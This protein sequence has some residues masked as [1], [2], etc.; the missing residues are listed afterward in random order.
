MSSNIEYGYK[1]YDSTL[2]PFFRKNIN[3]NTR[4]HCSED[5]MNIKYL[6][7]I[8]KLK[9]LK[10][11]KTIEDFF[12]N[13]N[14]YECEIYIKDY[15][16]I[17]I[18]KILELYDFYKKDDIENIIDIGFIYQGMGHIKVIYYNTK[19]NKLFLRMDGGSNAYDRKLNYDLMKEI[20]KKDSIESINN[21]NY[22]FEELL[23]KI[24]NE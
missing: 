3:E 7:L 23:E 11:P 10:L 12:I 4:H 8:D 14:A 20:S 19:F 5:I 24:N 21:E 17:S 13:N 22:D 15:T 18:T 1:N 9:V 16:F 2:A 6:E